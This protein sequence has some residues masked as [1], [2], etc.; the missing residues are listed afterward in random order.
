MIPGDELRGEPLW[1]AGGFHYDGPYPHQVPIP[2][3]PTEAFAMIKGRSER[4]RVSNVRR[5]QRQEV[6]ANRLPQARRNER[7]GEVVEVRW[8]RRGCLTID[9]S[10]K[11]ELF[12]V[13][14]T[15][16]EGHFC[17]DRLAIIVT[18]SVERKA[19]KRSAIG[20][21]FRNEIDKQA[22]EAREWQGV[23]GEMGQTAT[24]E[25]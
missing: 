3:A 21:H 17:V 16:D 19:F 15:R 24:S 25:D 8:K 4:R 1:E 11:L 13:S 22:G 14:S 20:L 10:Y 12:V 2:T 7:K 23:L 6:T 18:V 5:W 9:V